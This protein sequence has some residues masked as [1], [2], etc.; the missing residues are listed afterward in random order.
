MSSTMEKLLHEAKLLGLEGTDIRAYV[1]ERQDAEREERA[2]ERDAAK[3]AAERDAA[4]LA[5]E[6]RERQRQHELEMKR[7]ELEATRS[8]HDVNPPSTGISGAKMPKLPCFIDG[9]DAIDSYLL[10]F[11]RFARQQRWDES[12]WATCL[13]ALLTGRALDTYSRMP[14]EDASQYSLLKAALF[15][16]YDLT[17]DGYRKK[18][19]NS[20][21]E[22]YES[23]DQFIDR[24]KNYLYK[25]MELSQTE[26]DY[27][28]VMD[29]FVKEQFM[30]AV[31]QDLAVHLRERSPRT[32][33]EIGGIAAQYL[34]AH[35]KTLSSSSRVKAQPPTDGSERPEAPTTF[36]KPANPQRSQ[37]ICFRCG[38]P[39]HHFSNC[40]T[41]TN[42]TRTTPKCFRCGKM[43]HTIKECKERIFNVATAIHDKPENEQNKASAINTNTDFPED[44]QEATAADLQNY[45][46]GNKLILP[47]GKF[48][49]Y[50]DACVADDGTSPLPVSIGKVGHHRVDILRDTGCSGVIVRRS[51]V[52]QKELTGRYNFI[53]FLDGSFK[54][55]PVA[56]IQVDSPYFTGATDALCIENAVYGLVIGNVPGTRATCNLDPNWRKMCDDNT[57]QIKGMAKNYPR[58]RHNNGDYKVL[59]RNKRM[60]FQ[61][62]DNERK[63][64]RRR[65]HYQRRLDTDVAAHVI[66][67]G[68]NPMRERQHY[69][70]QHH[71]RRHYQ[72]RRPTSIS[73]PS[74]DWRKRGQPDK[75][76]WGH[77]WG[78]FHP[79][80]RM[81][82]NPFQRHPDM[83]ATFSHPEVL[84]R[85]DHNPWPPHGLRQ[86]LN[87]RYTKV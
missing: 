35:H 74:T 30:D 60:E 79:A 23:P 54:R 39:G 27:E 65:R 49:P 61:T 16:R 67:T 13:S 66:R 83:S 76:H 84:Q 1:K 33:T 43:G 32:L 40:R 52:R 18:F 71:Q 44:A 25:W 41:T 63:R 72:R 58:I 68:T 21:P 56:R 38:K 5:A 14:E 11:E 69:E 7:L 28:A 85:R 80:P 29:M 19:R 75:V 31:P 48:V 6:D 42:G 34:T 8:S 22:A 26:K 87:G 73:A 53:R 20:K 64:T 82:N 15:T 10:R 81:L 50:L 51:L 17:E 2:A 59:N 12:Q 24:L 86:H 47:N 45:T 62:T 57:N 46:K 4:I 70:R 3:L 36:P 78:N 37:L 55:A 77:P 9:K